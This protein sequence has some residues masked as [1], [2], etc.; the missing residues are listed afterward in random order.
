MSTRRE[1]HR[2]GLHLERLEGRD[3]PS[4]LGIRAVR[5]KSAPVTEKPAAFGAFDPGTK[6]EEP[7]PKPIGPLG[8]PGGTSDNPEVV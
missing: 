6:N 7:A 3:L 5:T 1:R 8:G 2:R 4:A